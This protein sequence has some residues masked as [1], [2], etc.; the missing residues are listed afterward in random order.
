MY[1]FSCRWLDSKPISFHYSLSSQQ[2]LQSRSFLQ[3]ASDQHLSNCLHL[4]LTSYVQ[5]HSPYLILSDYMQQPSGAEH[6]A[7]PRRNRWWP[8]LTHPCSHR[9]VLTSERQ[10]ISCLSHLILLALPLSVHSRGLL[11][12]WRYTWCPR[13]RL[14]S[15]MDSPNSLLNYQ[16]SALSGGV[17]ELSWRVAIIYQSFE[18]I[19]SLLFW[20]SGSVTQIV[21][22]ARGSC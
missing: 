15:F 14:N 19:I 8:A 13:I 17:M 20:N 4:R 10:D 16:L 1:L 18:K 9:S 2:T 11:C 7:H 21:K 5:I 12:A 3:L 22:W 6:D